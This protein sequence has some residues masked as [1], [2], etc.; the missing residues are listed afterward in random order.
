MAKKCMRELMV[1]RVVVVVGLIIPMVFVV[2]AN[3]RSVR[4]LFTSSLH[5]RL[6]QS[7]PHDKSPR[8]LYNCLEI[9][10]ENCKE[11]HKRQNLEF[12]ECIIFNFFQCFYKLHIHLRV[13]E[14][15]IYA[16][17]KMCI[18]KCFP[19]SKEFNVDGA[20]CLLQCY[21]EHIKNH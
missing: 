14:D 19:K 8:A 2:Q 9:T 10:L 11:K 4:S 20:T 1:V 13:I 12:K 17:A 3:D 5:V 6:L 18:D 7:H 15:K 21:E 16:N